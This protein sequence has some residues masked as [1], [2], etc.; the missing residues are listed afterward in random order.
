[1]K[2]VYSPWLPLKDIMMPRLDGYATSKRIREL[3]PDRTLI[4]IAVTACAVK[5]DL[6]KSQEAGMDDFISKPVSLKS[7]QDILTKWAKV[8]ALTR[9]KEQKEKVNSKHIL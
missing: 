9:E 2:T 8:I 4:I 1:M 7:F 5:E 6:I 3:Y